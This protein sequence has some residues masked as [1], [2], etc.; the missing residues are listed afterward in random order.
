MTAT[1]TKVKLR[2][3]HIAPRKVRLVANLIKGMPVE[4][5]LAQLTLHPARSS[6]PL[7]KLIRSAVANA[8]GHGRKVEALAVK[9]IVVNEGP[10]IKRFLPRAR[11][12][13]TPIHKKMSHVTLVLEEVTSPQPVRFDLT[14]AEKRPQK[15]KKQPKAAKAKAVPEIKSESKNVS[16]EPG[17]FK[18]VFRRKAI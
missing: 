11:G 12:I 15:E 9:S 16:R 3:L 10:M 5:A 14:K 18:R 2:N 6:G 13:A 4:E 17:F 7:I 8:R 1:E